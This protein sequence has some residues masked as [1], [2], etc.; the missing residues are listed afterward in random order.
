M[1]ITSLVTRVLW[2][3]KLVMS[4]SILRQVA[5]RE[6]WGCT[7]TKQEIIG[8]TQAGQPISKG[9]SSSSWMDFVPQLTVLNQDGQAYQPY[10]SAGIP[11]SLQ[12]GS[13]VKWN[14]T[15]MQ[16]LAY[17]DSA[18]RTSEGCLPRTS[19]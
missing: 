2:E 10:G 9:K 19:L 4:M 15:D 18:R 7:T 16:A 6:V 14:P 12:G 3:C 5:Q 8:Y 11:Y 1:D 17:L 13:L